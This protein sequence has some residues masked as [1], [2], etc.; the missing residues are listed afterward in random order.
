[1]AKL[2]PKANKTNLAKLIKSKGYALPPL[3]KL[4][5]SKMG[6]SF[7]LRWSDKDGKR[8]SA[9]FTGAGG[10]PVLQVD[11]TWHNLT[12]GELIRYDL[13]EESHTTRKGC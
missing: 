2:F 7:F 9:Y 8:H 13:V 1:M 3:G 11:M 12:M 6:R 5:F 4:E 10:R